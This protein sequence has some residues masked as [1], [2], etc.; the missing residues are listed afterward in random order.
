MKYTIGQ[1]QT[2]RMLG[3]SLLWITAVFPS[4]CCATVKTKNTSPE[5]Q[6]PALPSFETIQASVPFSSW[7]KTHIDVAEFLENEKVF[8]QVLTGQLE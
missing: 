7:D 1:K 3:I 6:I 2:G 4:A 5:T 8:S